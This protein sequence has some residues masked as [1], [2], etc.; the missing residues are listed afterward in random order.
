MFLTIMYLL[1]A[2]V[3]PGIS[4]NNTILGAT[5]FVDT[6]SWLCIA[7]AAICSPA[8]VHT[9]IIHKHIYRRK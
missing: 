2:L 6:I 9:K 3:I 8:P 4:V 1:I 5:V 7:A